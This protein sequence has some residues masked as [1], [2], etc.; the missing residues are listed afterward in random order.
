MTQKQK[1]ERQRIL[2]E[3]LA[4]LKEDIFVELDRRMRE[5]EESLGEQVSEQIGEQIGEQVEGEVKK[6]VRKWSNRNKKI[7]N[8]FREFQ[9]NLALRH[10]ILYATMVIVGIML[11]WYGALTIIKVVPILNN[12]IVALSGGIILLAITGVVYKKLVG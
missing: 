11:F 8:D 5:T 1:E 9:E 6:Q 4:D 7:K 12:G 10:K 2:Q 3:I